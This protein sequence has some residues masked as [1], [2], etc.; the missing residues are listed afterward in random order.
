M[1]ARTIAIVGTGPTGIY[2]LLHLLDTGLPLAVTL[3]EKGPRAGIGMPYSP[4][5]S[6]RAMLANIASIEIPPIA[7]TYLDWLQDQPDARLRSYGL[8]PQDLDE[9]QFTPRLLLG[10]Y[11]RDQL[12]ALVDR[13][14]SRGHRIDI[15]EATEVLDIQADDAGLSVMTADGRDGPFDRV[16]VAT[17]HA[18]PDEGEAT[19]SYFPS[20]WS[21]LIEADIPAVRVGIMGTSL[22]SIDAAMAVVN[23]HGRFRRKGD[24]L[25]FD[26]DPVSADLRIVMMSRSG[27]LPEADFYCPIPYEPLTIATAPALAAC[28]STPAPLDAAFELVRAE[29]MQADPAFALRIGLGGLDADS[30]AD[31]YFAAR[32]AADPFKWAR[33]NLDEVEHNKAH[34]ITV[35]WRYALLRMH[36]EVEDIVPHLPEADRE[37]FDT[38]LKKVFVD[39]YAAVPSESIRRLLALRDAGILSLLALGEDYELDRQGSITRITHPDGQVD[40]FD[41]FIDARGQKALTS[42]DLPFPSLRRTLLENGQDIPD[43]SQDYSL[44]EAGPYTGRLCLAALPYLMHDRPFVQGITAC[45]DIAEAIAAGLTS[46]RRRRLVS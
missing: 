28:L 19:R 14:R 7:T 12:M 24:D 34:K 8:D 43:V 44:I 45:A 9:R 33:A 42:E 22:S 13:A 31:A 6:N 10:E 36:E 32:E 26:L 41:V 21:G 30:F 3:Y 17:G 4:E 23:Q 37:R 20:P 40:T 29:I 46:R 38:G 27:V 35:A 18:F 2:T 1:T 15:R 11:F 16:I 25:R 5:M 39:N